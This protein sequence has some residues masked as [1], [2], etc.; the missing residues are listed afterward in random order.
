MSV[1]NSVGMKLIDRLPDLQVKP[2][3]RQPH[4]PYYITN[5]TIIDPAEGKLLDGIYAIRIENGNIIS[6]DPQ[7]EPALDPAIRKVD[8]RGRYIC[9]GLIDAH[10]HV[11]AVPGVSVRHIRDLCMAPDYVDDG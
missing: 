6:V 7:S 8:A 10:V 3:V 1:S 11:C 9:P 5:A 4:E 2:W